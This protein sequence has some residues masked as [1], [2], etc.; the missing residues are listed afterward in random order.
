MCIS[1]SPMV[2]VCTVYA[3]IVYAVQFNSLNFCG[4]GFSWKSQCARKKKRRKSTFKTFLPD[5]KLNLGPVQMLNFTC[6]ESNN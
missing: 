6:T 1:L 4:K 3:C 2:H 5:K